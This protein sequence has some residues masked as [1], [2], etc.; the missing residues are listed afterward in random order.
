MRRYKNMHEYL[1]ILFYIKAIDYTHFAKTKES[2]YEMIYSTQSRKEKK[3]AYKYRVS[4]CLN[5]M[6]WQLI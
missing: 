6:I 5:Q 1:V 4:T 2:Y 3:E